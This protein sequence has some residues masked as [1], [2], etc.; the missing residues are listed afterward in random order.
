MNTP[1][2]EHFLARVYT[3][4]ELRAR[5]LDDPCGEAM[6]AGLTEEQG[7]ALANVDRVG[8]TMA[9]NSFARK[10]ELKKRASIVRRFMLTMFS[11]LRA[12]NHP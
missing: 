8:V 7:R 1:E 5:F 12:L 3:D 4:R 9:S 10:R 11:R 2:L 6:R